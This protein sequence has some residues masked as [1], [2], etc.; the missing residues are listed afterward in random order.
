MNAD[1][2]QDSLALIRPSRPLVVRIV[3]REDDSIHTEFPIPADLTGPEIT[4]W[5]EWLQAIT[6]LSI[7]SVETPD[8]GAAA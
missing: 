7:Y 3:H 2:F 8:S 6:D 4:K 1:D 5:V